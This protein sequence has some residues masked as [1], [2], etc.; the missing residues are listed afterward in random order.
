MS[1]NRLTTDRLVLTPATLGDLTDLLTLWK[2]EDFTRHIM[3]RALSEEEIWFR[4]LRDLGHW[5]ARGH[6]NWS[7]RLRDG[8]DY[9]G[10]VG[11]FDYRRDLD[12]P[13]DAPELGW[14]VAPAFQG[15]GY[16]AEALTAVL[17]WADRVLGAPR[18]V[19]M[20]APENLA[21]LKLA[22]RVG[23]RAYATAIYKDH[24]VQLFERPCA[25]A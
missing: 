2:N 10:S 9:V 8:G 12:P 17:G 4:L 5:A 22:A 18:T 20:I 19:C 24:S 7:V 21:S 15:R 23:Y 1:R 11:V 13:F 14:G 3:G 16:A 6:G 25:G